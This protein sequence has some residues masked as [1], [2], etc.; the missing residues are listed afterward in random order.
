MFTIENIQKLTIEELKNMLLENPDYIHRDIDGLGGVIFDYAVWWENYELI[1]FLLNNFEIDLFRK[2]GDD[3]TVLFLAISHRSLKLVKIL[4]D[5]GL[6]IDE[7][8]KNYPHLNTT[9]FS[10][11]I[12]FTSFWMRQYT[13]YPINT[14]K[15]SNNTHK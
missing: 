8:N 5:A 14:D 13:N 4:L 2:D 15:Q 1:F 3:E 7:K 11:T 12:I 10:T 6:P 9:I